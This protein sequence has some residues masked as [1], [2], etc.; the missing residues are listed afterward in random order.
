MSNQPKN[1]PDVSEKPKARYEKP[2]LKTESLTAVAALCNGSATGGR[3]ATTSLP[4]NC[5]ASKLK[6]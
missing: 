2:A 5:S 3:K 6:S 1:P 4:A